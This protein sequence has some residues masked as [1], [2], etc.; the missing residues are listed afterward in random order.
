[1]NRKLF[2]L[3]WLMGIHFSLGAQIYGCTDPQANNYDPDAS[4]NDGTCLYSNTTS[5]PNLS[6]PLPNGV[7]ETSGLFFFDGKY[8]THNDDTDAMFFAIDSISAEVVDTVFWD[9]LIN[10]DWEE[11][12]INE[13]YLVVG[14]IGNNLGNRTDLKFFLIPLF[15]FY[16]NNL[17]VVDTILFSYADQ[18]NFSPSLNNHD[19]DAEAFVVTMDSIFIFSKCWSSETTKR[20]ALPLQAGIQ[21]ATLRETYNTNG[22]ITGAAFFNQ[23][24]SIALTGYTAFLQP[25]V[26]LLSDFDNGLFFNGNK[27]RIELG[28]PFHQV[29]AIAHAHDFVFY[30]TNERYTGALTVEQKWHQW[31]AA[32][33]FEN[34]NGIEDAQSAFLEYPFPMPTEG[35]FQIKMYGPH[36]YWHYE[37]YDAQGNLKKKGFYLGCLMDFDISH[38]QDGMYYVHIVKRETRLVYPV[39]KQ[40][41]N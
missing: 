21:T 19:F 20:Y 2:W 22:L 23:N 30:L 29:E 16:S 39:M 10:V 17:S 40:S 33:F 32:A 11:C 9:G 15:D 7:S 38:Y 3:V 28:M 5:G 25:F 1:M 12:Q 34:P 13:S 6:L 35:P 14:D 4:I 26:W 18:T 31:N 36:C 41:K 37:I 27:R 8:W 24:Q